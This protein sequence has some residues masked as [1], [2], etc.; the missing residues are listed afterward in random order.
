MHTLLTWN[1]LTITITV[2]LCIFLLMAWK[3]SELRH[4]LTDAYGRSDRL[5]AELCIERTKYTQLRETYEGLTNNNVTA[6]QQ[7]YLWHQ[8]L[9]ELRESDIYKGD[10]KLRSIRNLQNA[11]SDLQGTITD[12][13]SLIQMVKSLPKQ[14]TAIPQ[15]F[16]LNKLFQPMKLDQ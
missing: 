6:L 14:K 15:S 9:E 10:L 12:P 16:D 5:Y 8:E 3:I 7:L 4:L 11:I 1:P 13:G 2:A